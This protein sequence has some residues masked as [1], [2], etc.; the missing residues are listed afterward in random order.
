[1][2]EIYRERGGELRG[3]EG[4]GERE[5]ERGRERVRRRESERDGRDRG[6]HYMFPG[7]DVLRF[8]YFNSRLA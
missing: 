8:V 3:R 5:G 6:Q 4:E 1:M 7:T 2:R